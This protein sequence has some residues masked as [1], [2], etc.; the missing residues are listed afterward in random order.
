[1]NKNILRWIVLLLSVMIMGIGCATVVVPRPELPVKSEKPDTNM[2]K[3]KDVIPEVIE[4]HSP[5]SL[6]AGELIEISLGTSSMT[7]NAVPAGTFTMGSPN[8]EKARDYDEGPQHEVTISEP[9]AMGTYEV[10]QA[11]WQQVMGENPAKFKNPQAPVEM[12][13][14][15]EAIEFCNRLSGLTG[16]SPAYRIDGK[17]VTYDPRKDGFRLPTEAEWEYAARGAGYDEYQL[18][19]GSDEIDAVGWYQ[20]NSEGT[21]HPV[22]RKA[23]NS[24][25][26]YDMTGNVWEWCWDWHDAGYYSVAP[27]A[28]PVGPDTG[29]AR[30]DRGGSWYNTPDK[31]RTAIR[32]YSRPELTR[33]TLGFRVIMPLR[34]IEIMRK[35]E[36]ATSTEAPDVEE[37]VALVSYEVG[38]TGPAGGIIAF[39]NPDSGSDWQYIEV[40]PIDWSGEETDPKYIWGAKNEKV[41]DLGKELGTG[42]DN[43]LRIVE[44]VSQFE[45]EPFAALVC[46]QLVYGGYDDWFLP[47]DEE[48]LLLYTNLHLKGLG[49]FSIKDG[50]YSST[51]GTSQT[52]HICSM[53]KGTIFSSSKSSPK[54]IR[55]IR[56]F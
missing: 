24:L 32:G 35:G 51:E 31:S 7:L 38:D 46:H 9:F 30:V 21:T 10:T 42:Y 28:D 19:T 56:R 23:P 11:L 40:A 6:Y 25:G 39:S 5:A 26:L 49:D 41:K 4:K 14:W 15:Y 12:V 16:R 54:Y 29:K 43:T 3:P 18:Y 2:D 13:S 53:K 20:K 27:S 17:R 45:S 34:G 1:M 22:G 52:A 44:F 33:E 8:S 37:D 48:L 50:Y 55:P 47:S 36:Q